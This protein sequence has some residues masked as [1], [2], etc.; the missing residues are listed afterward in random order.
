MLRRV[1]SCTLTDVP[2]L[3]SDSIIALMFGTAI[4]PL[5]LKLV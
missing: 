1:V 5:K 3:L 4:K 2:E